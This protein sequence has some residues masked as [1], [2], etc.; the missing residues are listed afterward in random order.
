[1]EFVSGDDNEADILTKVLSVKR[2]WKLARKILDHVLV[3]GRGLRGVIELD[4][5]DIEL[6]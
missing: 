4:A 1:M 6:G 5:D 3:S 2:Y